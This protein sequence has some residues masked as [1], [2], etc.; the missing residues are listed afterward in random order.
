MDGLFG[1]NPSF[2]KNSCFNVNLSI[3]SVIKGRNNKKEQYGKFKHSNRQDQ[4]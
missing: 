2:F 1:N 4:R 3:I